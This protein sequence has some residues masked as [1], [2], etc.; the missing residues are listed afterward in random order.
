M[1]PDIFQEKISHLMAGQEFVHT[2]MDDILIIS[3]S[4]FG[5][6]LCQLQV[7]LQ[8]LRRVGLKVNAEK[9]SFLAPEI[10]Y[11]LGMAQFTDML[12]RRSHHLAPLNRPCRSF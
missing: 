5:D 9:S 6:H 12:K 7:V 8:R 10:E 3:M 2:H 4:T 1:S 11:F